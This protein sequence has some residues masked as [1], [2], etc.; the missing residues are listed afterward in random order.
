MAESSWYYY[1][2]QMEGSPAEF[3]VDTRF[4]D[5]AP[6][7]N[8]PV[9][10]H[11]RCEMADGSALGSRARRHIDK[12]E[13]RCEADVKALYAGYIQDDY[14][15]VMFFYTD[16]P[17]RLGALE[18]IADREKYLLC[19]VGAEEDAQW[20][21]YLSVL[22]PDAAKYFTETNRKNAELYRKNGDCI[23][24][25]RRLTLHMFF[26]LEVLAKQFAEEARLAG[27]AIGD[28]EFNPDLDTQYGI[29]LHVISTLEAEELD[30]YTT[31]AI[32]TAERYSGRLLYWESPVIP[33][34]SPLR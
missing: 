13:K 8:R 3:A 5:R 1:D 17:A 22:Y 25:A 34:N 11:M 29:R 28:S 16:K 9:L 23:A 21:T 26:P 27:F 19:S 33:K 18:D 30:K 6:Y 31:L 4:F 2:W 14:R 12:L 10:M 20:S 24:A 7:P 32:Y 15:R